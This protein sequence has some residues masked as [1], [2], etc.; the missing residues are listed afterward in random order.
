MFMPV[1]GP[2]SKSTVRPNSVVICVFFLFWF[3]LVLVS[4]SI[5]IHTHQATPLLLST[6]AYHTH[7]PYPCPC[8]C[9]LQPLGQSIT[10]WVTLSHI[11]SLSY[12]LLISLFWTTLV[13]V[14]CT[15]FH[16]ISFHTLFSFVN[17]FKDWVL[18]F[19]LILFN[20]VLCGSWFMPHA[21]ASLLQL[22]C[23]YL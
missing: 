11:H 15:C 13:L 23:S 14:F 6:L 22:F 10:P 1:F 21:N 19:V 8:P 16:W 4:A 18:F 7:T 9:Q 5:H 12:R 17:W 2:F 20:L 3:S